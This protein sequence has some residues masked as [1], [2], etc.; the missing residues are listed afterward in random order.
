V[1]ECVK[2]TRQEDAR[3]QVH[4]NRVECRLSLLKPYL[5][6]LRG[7]SK[8]NLP[9]SVGCLQFLRNFRQHNAFAQAE[10]LLQAA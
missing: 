1:H 5:W 2:H 4:E 3:G 6:V 8:R 10:L 9:G 7:V